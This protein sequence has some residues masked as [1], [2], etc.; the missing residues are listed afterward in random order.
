[1][2]FSK[3]LSIAV[4][5]ASSCAAFGQAPTQPSWVGVWNGTFDGEPAVTLTLADDHGQLG[6]TIVFNIVLAQPQPHVLG[7]DPLMVAQPQ[8]KGDTLLF[9]ATRSRDHKQ[10]QISAK[11]LDDQHVEL[12]CLNC[13]HDSVAT[14]VKFETDSTN[15]EQRK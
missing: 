15:A 2:R 12:Q 1:M 5:C 8:L 13:G 4:V 3:L 14:L 9:Q 7:T 10:L 11:Q 6:G